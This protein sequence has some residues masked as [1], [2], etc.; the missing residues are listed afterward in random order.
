MTPLEEELTAALAASQRQVVELKEENELLRQK[1]D[2][3]VKRI[4]GAKSEKMNPAQLELF[5]AGLDPAGEPTPPADAPAATATTTTGDTLTKSPVVPPPPSRPKPAR[6]PRLPEHL[7]IVEEIVDPDIVLANPA[8]FRFVNQVVTEQ[9]DFVRG[10]FQR[11][12]IIRR[13]YVP[14]GNPEAAPI[15]APLSILQERCLAAPALL[16]NII[17]AKYCDALPLYRQEQIFKTR[18]NILLPRQT[19]ARWMAMVAFWFTGI[20]KEILK[21]VLADGYVECDETVIKYLDPGHGKTR[22]GYLW[23]VHRPGGDTVFHWYPSRAAACLDLI[24]PPWWCGIIGCDRYAGYISYATQRN[25]GGHGPGMPI[26]LAS[27]MTHIRRG[28]IESKEE[29]P[30][31]AGWI[32]RQIAHLYQLEEK[33]R[34]NKSS[35]ILRQAARAA[36]AAPILR[37]LEKAIILFQS[38]GRHLPKSG[39]G[40]ALQ[41]ARNALPGMNAYLTHG[42]VEVDNNLVENEIR[43]TAIGK[44]NF[45]FFGSEEAGEHSANIYTI[46]ASARRRGLDPEA[47]LT[48]IIRRLPIT[49]ATQMHTLTPAAWAAEQKKNKKPVPVAE[50][51]KE[52]S[53]PAAAIKPV[54]ASA[55]AVA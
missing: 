43:P 33:L 12:H 36:V 32:I 55:V 37:R 8:G 22:Q 28:F 41:Y 39:F 11:R 42:F 7:P 53:V 44:K 50:E 16:A 30:T 40:K 6:R 2:A 4:F 1:I 29:A 48:D 19:M 15:I 24:F 26:E 5:M 31:R 17:T 20:C 27:C 49:P 54:P 18:H 3:L 51:V 10:H 23:V 38:S 34:Q 25:E 46:V 9:L 45:L 47:Y 13:K 35:P 14:I 21:E 52:V